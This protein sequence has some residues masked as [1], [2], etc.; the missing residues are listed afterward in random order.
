MLNPKKSEKLA[1]KD[2]QYRL[3]AQGFVVAWPML[4]LFRRWRLAAVLVVASREPQQCK[5]VEGLISRFSR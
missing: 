3:F 5:F 2:D 1:S 4:Y